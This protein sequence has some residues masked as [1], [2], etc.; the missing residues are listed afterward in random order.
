MSGLVVH[1][2]TSLGLLFPSMFDAMS[3]RE[4]GRKT[5]GMKEGRKE[6]SVRWEGKGE[7]EGDRKM[8]Y[9]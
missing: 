4:G 8:G 3:Y 9:R 5:K 2:N 6:E 7:E 1:T